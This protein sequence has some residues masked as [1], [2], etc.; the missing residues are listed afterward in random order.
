MIIL[1]LT[2][3]QLDELYD[4][5]SSNGNPSARKKCLTA[6]LRAKSYPRDTI[7]LPL[8]APDTVPH[9]IKSYAD[10]DLEYLNDGIN[11]SLVYCL[12]GIGN[13]VFRFFQCN[14]NVALSTSA[15]PNL[16]P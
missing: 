14:L 5:L 3:Q 10:G 16:K 15:I 11:I 7:A 2:E 12:S 13:H 8:I 1:E 4:E 9:H 6:Y